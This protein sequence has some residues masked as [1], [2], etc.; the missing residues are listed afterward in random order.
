MPGGVMTARDL[1]KGDQ[2]RVRDRRDMTIIMHGELVDVH[3]TDVPQL[4]DGQMVT[5]RA[6]FATVTGTYTTEAFGED[7]KATEKSTISVPLRCVE[8]AGI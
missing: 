1:A 8:Y 3:E 4:V 5:V 7:L 6:K 2:V